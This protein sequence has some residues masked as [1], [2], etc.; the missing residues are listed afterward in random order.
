MELLK[1]RAC[2]WV[3]VAL[4]LVC[5][6]RLDWMGELPAACSALRR[7]SVS[8]A[9]S[10]SGVGEVMNLSHWTSRP[11]WDPAGG[12]RSWWFSCVELELLFSGSGTL[13]LIN[14][15]GGR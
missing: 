11:M 10:E 1:L 2:I 6:S 14:G 3:I 4:S 12:H 15:G 13:F 8:V 5:W 9:E 7:V